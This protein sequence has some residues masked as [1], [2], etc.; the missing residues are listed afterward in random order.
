M[1]GYCLPF[2]TEEFVWSG[3]GGGEGARVPAGRRAVRIFILSEGCSCGC[4]SER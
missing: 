1:A 3:A 2:I 4:T